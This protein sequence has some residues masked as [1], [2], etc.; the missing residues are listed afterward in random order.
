MEIPGFE[1]TSFEHEGRSHPVF[2]AGEGP[3]V[4]ILHELPGMTEA[5]IALGRRVAAAG[6]AVHLPLM[7]GRPGERAPL[8]F[9]LKLCVSREFRLFAHRRSS[10]I[11]DWLRGLCRW[12]H[13]R[14]GGPGVGVIGM[15]LTGNFALTLA[16]DEAVMAPV[17]SQP[18][19]PLGFG[20]G[21]KSALAL[22]P[23]ELARV[24]ERTAGGLPVLGLRFSE[25]QVCPAERFARLGQ[26]LGPAFEPLVIDSSEGNPHGLSAQAHSVL[27]QELVDEEG[28]PTRQALQRVLAFLGER[29]RDGRPA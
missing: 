2:G 25:D 20:E 29:L 23:E 10:P 18:S 28:H 11:T 15:C 3:G 5:C 16:A 6:Y 13:G 9:M 8:K 24:K 12:V 19:L 4:V 17:M 1:T 27:T 14:C 22:S 7:F 21:R 26:E